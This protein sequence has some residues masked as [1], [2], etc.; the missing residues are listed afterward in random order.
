MASEHHA[1]AGRLFAEIAQSH[2]L[3]LTPELLNRIYEYALTA[4]GTS[5]NRELHT[6]RRPGLLQ[7]CRQLRKESRLF[8]F[9]PNKFHIIVPVNNTEEVRRWAAAITDK[10][11]GEQ[12]G[13]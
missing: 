6:P 5:R 7:V 2:L 11:Q 13:S 4:D 10:R 12:R 9:W 1:A 8:Y 3:K